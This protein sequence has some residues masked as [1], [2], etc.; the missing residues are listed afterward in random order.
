M[1]EFFQ[2]Y[3]VHTETIDYIKGRMEANVQP[4]YEIGVIEAR[5]ASIAASAKFSQQIDF[6]GTETEI[7]VPSP[8]DKG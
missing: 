2:K 4:Y 5:K 3:D 6:D 1:E 8:Y 7:S